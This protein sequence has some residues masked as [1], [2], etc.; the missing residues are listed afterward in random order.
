MKIS[1]TGRDIDRAELLKAVARMVARAQ[2]AAL[3]Q[4]EHDHADEEPRK[5]QLPVLEEVVRDAG[6]VVDRVAAV[7][8]QKMLKVLEGS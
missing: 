5:M 3:P 6:P 7:M 4:D 8:R 1:I 2:R